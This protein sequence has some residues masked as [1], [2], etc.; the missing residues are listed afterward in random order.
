M[1]T[2]TASQRLSSVQ[3]RALNSYIDRLRLRPWISKLRRKLSEKD[4]RRVQK[5]A[6]DAP[7][8][9]RYLNANGEWKVCRPQYTSIQFSQQFSG[10]LRMG[11]KFMRKSQ[12]Y[13]HGYGKA[14]QK[15]HSAWMDPSLVTLVSHP[16]PRLSAPTWWRFRSACTHLAAVQWLMLTP[17]P[18][19]AE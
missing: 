18:R 3:R 19:T 8:T 4:K 1:A 15:L 7:M 13:P 11:T 12:I 2:A 17:Y 6:K 5:K 9:R 10:R 16:A 14:V